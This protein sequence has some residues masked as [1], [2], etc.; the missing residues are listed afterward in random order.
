MKTVIKGFTVW[1][2]VLIIGGVIILALMMYKIYLIEE[3]RAKYRESCSK[4][5]GEYVVNACYNLDGERYAVC[6][7]KEIRKVNLEN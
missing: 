6:G 1:P 5:C 3:N 7:N 4:T 2:T